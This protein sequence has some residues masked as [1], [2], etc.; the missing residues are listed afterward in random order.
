MSEAA[1]VGSTGRDAKSGRGMPTGGQH[2]KMINA[3][4]KDSSIALSSIPN[5]S[6]DAFHKRTA[7]RTL[8]ADEVGKLPATHRAA[9]KSGRKR[10]GCKHFGIGKAAACTCMD[11]IFS[12]TAVCAKTFDGPPADHSSGRLRSEGENVGEDSTS[13]R[14][15]RRLNEVQARAGVRRQTR[16]G[17]HVGETNTSRGHEGGT[18][19]SNSGGIQ[20]REGPSEQVHFRN[21]NRVNSESG[22]TAIMSGGSPR[23]CS[24]TSSG[25][26]SAKG[27]KHHIRRDVK[28]CERPSPHDA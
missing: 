20:T 18:R 10:S 27:G 2:R 6:N 21:A 12:P 17:L 14:L 15:P 5:Q 24:R 23:D 22:K 19:R 16:L 3:T 4:T 11:T 8:R 26:T 28:S 7:A 1:V 25:H 13:E 9:I